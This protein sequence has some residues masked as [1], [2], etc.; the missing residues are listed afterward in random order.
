MKK[1]IEMKLNGFGV[2][3]ILIDSIASIVWEPNDFGQITVLMREGEIE[4][5]PVA[6]D[7]EHQ[8]QKDLENCRFN[9]PKSDCVI[10]ELSDHGKWQLQ[11]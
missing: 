1:L 11:V 8:L 5:I 4:M 9:Y 6:R 3:A 2:R 7:A 10:W